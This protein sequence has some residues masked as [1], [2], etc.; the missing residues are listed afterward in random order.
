MIRI[1]R[2][3]YVRV[4]T[5]LDVAVHPLENEFLPFSAVTA[6]I[7]AG[8]AAI[9]IPNSTQLSQDQELVIWFSLPFQDENIDYIKVEAKILRLIPA[10]NVRFYKVPLQFKNIDE[11]TRQKLIRF[12]FQQQIQMRRKGLMA[13]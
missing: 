4:D 6:D 1:Q 9:L 12:C 10:E 13:E 7:S 2:R 5:T 11:L 3:E 8:G